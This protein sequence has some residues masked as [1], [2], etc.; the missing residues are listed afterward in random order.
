MRL[1]NFYR[2]FTFIETAML[3]FGLHA[4]IDLSSCFDSSIAG[5]T[6]DRHAFVIKL[7]A[8]IG[9]STKQGMAM[10]DL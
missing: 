10:G 6:L 8:T 7:M 2:V 1:I 3:Y 5:H 4:S 9:L